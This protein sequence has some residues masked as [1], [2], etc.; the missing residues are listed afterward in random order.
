MEG[1]GWEIQPAGWLVLVIV[2]FLLIYFTI[3]WLKRSSHKTFGNI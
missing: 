1:I 2:G 3:D